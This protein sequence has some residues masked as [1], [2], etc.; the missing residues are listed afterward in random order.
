MA[1]IAIYEGF[2]RRGKASGSK[3]KTHAKR[4]HHSG[5]KKNTP[6]ARKFKAA[7]AHCGKQKHDGTI[8]SAQK[9]LGACIRKYY[10]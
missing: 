9:A 4:K 7:I 6:Q 3:K 10:K 5:S 2:G 1:R 8:H